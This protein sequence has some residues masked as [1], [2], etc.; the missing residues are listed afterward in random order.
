MGARQC[1]FCPNAADS[2]EHLWPDWALESIGSQFVEMRKGRSASKWFRG[3][4]KVKHVCEECNHGWMSDLETSVRPYMGPM[5]HGVSLSLRKD[6]QTAIS[7]WIIKTAMVLQA[8]A[9]SEHHFYNRIECEALRSSSAIPVRSLIWLGRFSGNGLLADGIELRFNID[10]VPKA[11]NG[12][13]TT[14]ILGQFVAQVLTVHY[15]PEQH[16]KNVRIHCGDGPWDRALINIWPTSASVEWPATL[17]FTESSFMPYTSLLGRWELG[18][19]M[20]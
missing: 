8:T 19:R 7:F 17:S 1:I 18:N 20:K 2:K 13:V 16:N 12:C 10:N 14:I 15:G 3:P 6:Q 11:A 9:S 4:I 5:L